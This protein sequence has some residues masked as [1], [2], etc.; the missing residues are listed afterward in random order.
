[1]NYLVNI[2]KKLDKLFSSSKTIDIDKNSRIV[3]MSDCHRG[4]GNNEDSFLKNEVIFNGA[5]KQYFKGGYTYIELGDGDELWEVDDI[6]YIIASHK[7]SYKIL[8]NFYKQDRLYMIVGNHDLK[9][10][11]NKKMYNK[12]LKNLEVYESL[13]LNYDGISIFLIHGHQVDLMNSKLAF[14]SKF[15]VRHVWKYLERFG[16]NDPTSAAKNNKLSEF[17]HNELIKFSN[18]KNVIVISGHTHKPSL[19]KN[20]LYA[21]SGSCVHPNGI[22]AIEIEHGYLNLVRWKMDAN[23][24]GTAKV[25]R[26]KI[27]SVSINNLI[28]SS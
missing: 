20:Q 26:E 1:M 3:I 9:K 13:I 2:M 12:Y 22:T 23:G 15:M 24:E 10:L 6:E 4:D 5:L 11:N 27:S 14:I 28:N 18:T 8:D 19:D 21:N 7:S 25:V 16:I 17:T